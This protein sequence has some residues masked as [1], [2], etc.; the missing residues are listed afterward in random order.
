[1]LNRTSQLSL[2]YPLEDQK[3]QTAQTLAT[4]SQL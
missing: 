3:L 4:C 1:M 2:S